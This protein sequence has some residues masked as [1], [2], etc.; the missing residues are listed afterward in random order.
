[1]RCRTSVPAQGGH[2]ARDQTQQ[3][4]TTLHNED[5]KSTTNGRGHDLF[6]ISY[7]VFNPARTLRFQDAG[8]N[9][10]KTAR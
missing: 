1:L 7:N 10:A 6:I 2:A 5:D 3:A 4:F 8:H 9:N